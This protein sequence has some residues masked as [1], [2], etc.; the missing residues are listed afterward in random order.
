MHWEKWNFSLQNRRKGTSSC[1]EPLLDGDWFWKGTRVHHD[2]YASRQR[3]LSRNTASTLALEY[4]VCLH[5]WC[6]RRWSSVSPRKICR[7]RKAIIGGPEEDYDL[8]CFD[9]TRRQAWWYAPDLCLSV[10]TRTSSVMMK[11]WMFLWDS[12][13]PFSFRE[14]STPRGPQWSKANSVMSQIAQSPSVSK[15]LKHVL[16]LFFSVLSRCLRFILNLLLFIFFLVTPALMNSSVRV[17]QR[18]TWWLGKMTYF[19]C[20]ALL[21]LY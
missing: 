8:R 9:Q 16:F 10:L 14:C 17:E 4:S 1:E 15:T 5:C 12:T 20:I 6:K 11:L 2:L 21:R 19:F 13:A 18:I 7:L 3:N